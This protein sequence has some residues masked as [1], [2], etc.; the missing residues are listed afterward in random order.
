LDKPANNPF[1]KVIEAVFFKRILIKNLS[2]ENILM[3][4]TIK[5]PVLEPN[6]APVNLETSFE[7]KGESTFALTLKK[8]R[9]DEPFGEFTLELKMLGAATKEGYWPRQLISEVPQVREGE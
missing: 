5:S 4:A 8:H 6:F 3:V 2:S 9:A 7:V 1:D